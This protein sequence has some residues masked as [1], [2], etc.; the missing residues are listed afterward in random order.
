LDTRCNTGGILRFREL[1]ENYPVAIAADFRNHYNLSVFEAGE[2]YTYKEAIFLTAA[3]FNDTESLLF[4]AYHEWEYPVSQEFLAIADLFDLTF[5]INSKKKRQRYRR[6]FKMESDD[7]K[8][9]GK[10][11]KSKQEIEKIL[12][13]MNPNRSKKEN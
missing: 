2:T 12:Q 6:P 10:T 7:T 11:N 13:R 5:S 8:R 9:Y 4:T 1:I 3:L